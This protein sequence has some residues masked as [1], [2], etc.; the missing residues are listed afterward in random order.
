MCLRAGCGGTACLALNGDIV[1]GSA[2]LPA[3]RVRSMRH[4]DL[5]SRLTGRAFKGRQF[6]HTVSAGRS[7][8]ADRRAPCDAGAGA[9]AWWPG[10]R[11]RAAARAGLPSRYRM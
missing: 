2:G 3:G 11:S 9:A 10:A 1:T 4:E 6:G 8:A 7:T 5:L